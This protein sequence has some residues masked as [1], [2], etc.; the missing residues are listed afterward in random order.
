M[1]ILLHFNHHFFNDNSRPGSQRRSTDLNRLGSKLRNQS[2]APVW[3]PE[4]QLKADFLY[5]PRELNLLPPFYSSLFTQK[6]SFAKF[7]CM[8]SNITSI[9]IVNRRNG[10]FKRE[11]S[12][13]NPLCTSTWSKHV[14]RRDAS[15]K[16]KNIDVVGFLFPW[17]MTW[18][19]SK[20]SLATLLSE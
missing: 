20:F 8:V 2:G 18:R 12:T 19:L 17:Y 11:T 9:S 6:K 16:N 13:Q 14:S 3:W 15:V 10:N 5:S 1:L 4:R 7:L